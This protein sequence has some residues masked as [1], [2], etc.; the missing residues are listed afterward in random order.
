[1]MGGPHQTQCQ[2]FASL[3][4]RLCVPGRRKPGPKSGFGGPYGLRY[5]SHEALKNTSQLCV[6]HWSHVHHRLNPGHP[7]YTRRC[8]QTECRLFDHIA[9]THSSTSGP[10]PSPSTPRADTPAAHSSPFILYAGIGVTGPVVDVVEFWA[11]RPRGARDGGSRDPLGLR[12]NG[13]GRSS[14]MADHTEALLA[15]LATLA[16]ESARARGLAVDID[17][18]VDACGAESTA[19]QVRALAPSLN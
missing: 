12:T 3:A 14:P 10:V 15:R 9:L 6:N 2:A 18:L 17:S 4:H 13:R 1:M 11:R 5:R 19:S 8:Y 7:I 16:A